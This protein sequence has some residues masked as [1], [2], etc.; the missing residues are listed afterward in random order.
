MPGYVPT[1]HQTVL[2]AGLLDGT[3][4]TTTLATGVFLS[5]TLQYAPTE[6]WLDTRSLSVTKVAA[7]T[8]RAVN[9]VARP[10]SQLVPTRMMVRAR[11]AAVPAAPHVRSW[12][13]SLPTSLARRKSAAA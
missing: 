4:Q 2:K 7:A 12:P 9:S 13:P 8:M 6:V 10:R 3:F 1:A 11:S 5:S